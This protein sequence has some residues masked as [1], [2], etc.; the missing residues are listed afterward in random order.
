MAGA[1]IIEYEEGEGIVDE[2]E[3]LT[4]GQL[5]GKENITDVQYGDRLTQNQRAQVEE[6]IGE[7]SDV[8]TDIPGNTNLIE[9]K[10]ETT[11]TIPVKAK[12]YPVPYNM[13]ESLSQDIKQMKEMGVIRESQSPYAAP[14]VIVRKK[15]GSNRVC[16]DFR[17][18]N[19]VSVFDNEPMIRPQ[20]IFA[21]IDK[22]KYYSKFDMTKGYWQIPMR[23]EDIQ[24]TAFVTPDGCYEFLRMPF[25]LM[26][27]G[28]TFTKL[29][30][31]VTEGL[32]GVEHYIDDCLIHSKTWE[33]HLDKLRQFLGRVRQASLTVRP[34]K[35]QIAVRSVEF[36]GHNVGQGEI[37]VQDGNVQKVLDAPRPQTKTQVRAFLGLTGF[38]R[39]YIPAYAEIAV[40]LTDL[41]KKGKPNLVEWDRSH[42]E[43]FRT[44]K[45]KIA[46]KPVLKLPDTEKPFVLRTDASDLGVGAM[47]MQEH[48][49]KLF[50]VAYASKKLLARERAYSIME[51][52]CLA[53]VWAVKKFRVYLYGAP[54][55]LQTDHQPLAYLNRARFTNDRITRWALFLQPFQ[56][57]IQAIK[58]S[59]NVGADY[60]SRV[61][62]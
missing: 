30:R 43:A 1:S 19:R 44:L 31:K 53:I 59:Q 24:K 22:A 28:A 9:H 2:E 57:E 55:V 12:Q 26:N 23:E 42:D 32:E 34:S 60:L 17:Q 27:S 50:P 16:V 58:G 6:I 33:E 38:Y 46:M 48:E 7:F 8:F 35:C 25:G 49:G 41:T 4:L 45:H 10:I 62:W 52:E 37:G 51:K 11:S 18:L 29:M 3:L 56:I 14:V 21:K 20:D 15:D 40:P 5:R 47:L 13:R 54:F 36:V 39:E 61:E